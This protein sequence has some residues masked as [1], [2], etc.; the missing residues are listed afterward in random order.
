MAPEPAGYVHGASLR[1]LDGEVAVHLHR[2]GLESLDCVQH[3]CKVST[4]EQIDR[5]LAAEIAVSA[6][7]PDIDALRLIDIAKALDDVCEPPGACRGWFLL[8]DGYPLPNAGL[9]AP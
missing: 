7:N 1:D 5:P 3:R 9:G 4:A 6:V 8:A 2:S